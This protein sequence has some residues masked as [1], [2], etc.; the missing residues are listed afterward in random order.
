[1]SRHRNI[2]IIC[3]LLLMNIAAQAQLPDSI[4]CC[5]KAIN[6][7]THCISN[8]YG[9]FCYDSEANLQKTNQNTMELLLYNGSEEYTRIYYFNKYIRHISDINYNFSAGF[10]WD[11]LTIS[12][13]KI[14]A[15]M[16]VEDVIVSGHNVKVAAIEI[17]GK[18]IKRKK[19]IKTQSINLFEEDKTIVISPDSLLISDVYMLSPIGV[20]YP[21]GYYKLCLFYKRN[22]DDG[23]II[24]E[25]IVKHGK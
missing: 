20:R 1:M 16:I 21:D 4:Y 11:F 2:I 18:I 5:L 12:N 23:K 17:K 19:K 14:E 3:V 10:Y 15:E 8:K 22:K 9:Y 13:E 24:A 7:T 6:S 25:I